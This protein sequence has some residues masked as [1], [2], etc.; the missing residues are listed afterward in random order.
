MSPLA[1]GLLVAA[2]PLGDPNFD[3]SVVLLASHGP[4]GAFGWV[5]N[6]REL[7]SLS[8]LLVRA[9]VTTTPPEVRGVV[10]VGGPVS[11]EQIWL[12]YRIQDKFDSIEGQFDVG[13]EIL[14]TASRKVLEALGEGH[15]HGS[16]VGLA[17]YA[18]WAPSQ[19]ESEI[20]KGAWLPMEINPATVFDVPADQVW[21][22]AYGLVGATPMS[23]TTRTVGLA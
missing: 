13:S 16:V 9:E 19:L 18:G 11:Q 17:G 23:F 12:V 5:I 6:G 2:P 21:Q 4:E 7:M 10:R 15:K 14:A 20:R 3:R 8:D 22:H 1:P